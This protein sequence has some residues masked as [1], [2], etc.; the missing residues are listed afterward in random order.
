M[1]KVNVIFFSADVQTN[2][3]IHE[4]YI[5]PCKEIGEGKPCKIKRGVIGNMTFHYTPGKY[6]LLYVSLFV[7]TNENNNIYSMEEI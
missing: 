1:I 6:L 3:T 4:V 2:C 7:I 5:D